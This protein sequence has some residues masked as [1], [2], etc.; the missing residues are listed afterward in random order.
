MSCTQ[1]LEA[2]F[3]LYS[4]YALIDNIKPKYMAKIKLHPKKTAINGFTFL[5]LLTMSAKKMREI[6]IKN[7]A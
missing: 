6:I 3:E 2:I 1:F 7:T 4:L 5:K